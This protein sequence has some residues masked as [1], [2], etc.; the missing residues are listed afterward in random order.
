MVGTKLQMQLLQARFRKLNACSPYFSSFILFNHIEL[1]L[2]CQT[3]KICKKIFI[4]G[5]G[6]GGGQSIL[7]SIVAIRDF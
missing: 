4:G 2:R 6:G 3:P 5:G 7:I 1:I